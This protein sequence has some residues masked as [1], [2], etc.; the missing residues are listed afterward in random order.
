MHRPV[1][2]ELL[3]GVSTLSDRSVQRRTAEL[4][5]KPIETNRV[6]FGIF[7]SSFLFLWRW[8]PAVSS[9]SLELV[10]PPL[11]R[12]THDQSN[13]WNQSTR[14][15]TSH[16]AAI[17]MCTDRSVTRKDRHGRHLLVCGPCCEHHPSRASWPHRCLKHAV[18]GSL[19]VCTCHQAVTLSPKIP[20]ARR[21]I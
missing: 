8:K 4:K 2:R 9:V 17:C 1:T 16:S 10:W 20:A 5:A 15:L 14:P 21:L 13:S 7:I 18:A 12:Y 3:F 11:W 6:L 19:A